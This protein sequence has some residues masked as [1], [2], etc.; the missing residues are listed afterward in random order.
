MK[1]LRM[2]AWQHPPE[3][4]DVPVPEPGPGQVV[5]KVA[6]SGACHSDLHVMEWPEGQL[7]WHLPFTLG[8]ETSGWVH[9]IGP[10]VE[11]LGEGDA[12]LVYG[13]WG[14]GRCRACRVGMENYCEHSADIG[15]AGG[16]LGRDGGMAEYML[17]PRAR[18]LV[19]LGD[20][21]P[22]D[23]AP[24]ADAA[25]TPYH[26]IKRSLGLLTPGSAAV[27][28]GVGGLGHVGV[29]LLKALSPAQVIA[30]DLAED[31]LELARE[32]GADE[33]VR[34]DNETGDRIRD[35]TGGLGAELVVDFVGADPTLALGARATQ[36]MGHL[37]VI[38]LAGG[39]LEYSFFAVPYEV[40]LAST[41]WGSIPELMEVVELARGG[42]IN[43]RVER[44]P[45]ERA[46]ESYERMRQGTLG[47][48]AVIVP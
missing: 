11:G 20:L 43:I 28:I 33:T 7:P 31:K 21:D 9:A 25:L 3:L 36:V 39:K 26:A 38:G 23:A 16:G 6:G 14:E 10:G 2:T 24:L 46:T 1:A 32:V 18:W 45:L 47:G 27:V 5:I 17:V 29:E 48:R 12:V 41:Y 40:S 34:A 44:F 30:V 42:K 35:L 37:T 19:P 4:V 8:H 13:P 15:A 22:V